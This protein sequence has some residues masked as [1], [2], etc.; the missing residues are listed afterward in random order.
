VRRVPY[1]ALTLDQAG[2]VLSLVR[3]KA[4]VTD[5][6]PRTGGQLSTVYEVRYAGSPDAV[7]VKIYAEQWRWKLAPAK[8]TAGR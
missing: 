7:I 1:R 3:P 8:R 4:A 2:T 5:V 6:I